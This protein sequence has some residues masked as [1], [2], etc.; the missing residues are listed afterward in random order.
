LTAA[1]SKPRRG[2]APASA[3][4][5]R[6]PSRLVNAR[7]PAP[8]P[9]SVGLLDADRGLA[10]AVPEAERAA[11]WR[12]L[13]APAIWLET[14]AVDLERHQIPPMA[15]ALLL[16]EG[17]L[18]KEVTFHDRALIEILVEGDVLLPWEP[19]VDGLVAR[20]HITVI[21]PVRLAVLD[22]RFVHGAARWPMLMLDIQ[23]R[24]SDQEHRIAVHGAICQLPRVEQRIV[25]VLR[26]L[27][28]RIGRVSLL[29]TIVPLT[30]THEAL[31]KLIGARRST[32]TLALKGLT[33]AG[34]VCRCPDG[35]WMIPSDTPDHR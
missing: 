35:T 27:A 1:T 8:S 28:A 26:H 10:R 9:R 29:G 18:S 22:Q 19:E 16:V 23:R 24:L 12:A 15:F 5:R 21:E 30:L 25:A 34:L 32:V 11:A 6:P 33:S 7:L 20:R 17:I 14:G 13:V 3:A 31:G 2:E 4:L